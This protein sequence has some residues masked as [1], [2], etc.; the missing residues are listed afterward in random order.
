[1]NMASASPRGLA[2]GFQGSIGMIALGAVFIQLS[3]ALPGWAWAWT[4]GFVALGLGL[5]WLRRRKD[6]PRHNAAQ[7]GHIHAQTTAAEPLQALCTSV[8][9]I[10][11]RQMHT[12]REH[13]TH[14]MDVL[15]MRFG[16]MSQRLCQTMDPTHQSQ[17]QDVLLGALTDAQNQLTALLTE[18]REALSLRSALL[19]EVVAV[20][21]FVG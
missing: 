2:S 18:L 5:A 3:A 15:V 13:L 9:P 17:G 1:M 6:M 20:T 19:S 11:T 12:A 4:L 10:W 21:R 14:A 16:S 7:A 8:L